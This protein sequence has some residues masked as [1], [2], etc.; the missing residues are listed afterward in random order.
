[1]FDVSKHPGRTL[2]V[3][4]SFGMENMWQIIQER[5]PFG[6]HDYY[7]LDGIAH[8][9]DAQGEVVPLLRLCSY[10]KSD[11]NVQT[12]IIILK[13]AKLYHVIT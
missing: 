13:N 4:Q 9:L 6:P 5:H 10:P 3:Q 7:Q 12:L 8:A 1:M 11:S 2:Q